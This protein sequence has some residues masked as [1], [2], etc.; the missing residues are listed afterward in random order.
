M[1]Y[2]TPQDKKNQSQF[3]LALITQIATKN[4]VLNF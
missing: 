2:L 4:K 1:E 3:K